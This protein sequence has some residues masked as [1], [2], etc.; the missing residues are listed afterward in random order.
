[1]KPMANFWMHNGLLRRSAAGKIGGRAEREQGQGEPESVE[2]AAAQKLSRSKG[3]GGL[4]DQIKQFGGETIRFFLL[5]THYRST[6]LFGDSEMAEAK[7]GLETFYRFF[8]RYE[9]VTGES[10]Y[11]ISAATTREEGNFDPHGNAILAQAAEARNDFLESMDDDFNT[12]G[13]VSAMF[14]LVR[15]LNKTVDTAKLEDPSARSDADLSAFQRAAATLKELAATLG[16]FL[17]PV[18]DASGADDELAAGLMQLIIELRAEARKNKDWGTADRIR[19]GLKNLH[20]VLEDRAG[21]TEWSV[22]R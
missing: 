22:E 9:R 14:E 1:G 10:F 17:K 15:A 5:R 20:V 3:A 11:T 19:D 4:A 18:E 2:Q 8:K 16:L 6:V 12:G 13:G 7:Q 21:G